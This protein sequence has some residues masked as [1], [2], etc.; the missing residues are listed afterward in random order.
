MLCQ[1]GSAHSLLQL[2]V[3]FAWGRKGS[4]TSECRAF[5][6]LAARTSRAQTT[7]PYVV[8]AL[9]SLRLIQNTAEQNPTIILRKRMKFGTDIT[10]LGVWGAIAV[11]SPDVGFHEE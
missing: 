6:G 8:L 4:L 9:G 7:G 3:L 1:T 5:V 11:Y 2:S 10:C